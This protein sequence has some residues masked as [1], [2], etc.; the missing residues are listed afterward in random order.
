MSKRPAPW[1]VW[2]RATGAMAW[3]DWL[4][5]GRS[6]RAAHRGHQQGEHGLA[7][8]TVCSA[9]FGGAVRM[10]LEQRRTSRREWKR[11]DRE[12]AARRKVTS[13]SH[14]PS[15]PTGGLDPSRP[16]AVNLIVP[17]RVYIDT[18]EGTDDPASHTPPVPP[19]HSTPC[20]HG[21]GCRRRVGPAFEPA[22]GTTHAHGAR[23]G[24]ITR[25]SRT[26]IW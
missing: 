18:L 21:P 4:R 22:R 24:P 16:S 26:P 11:H 1:G 14:R 5:P 10:C 13:P 20:T 7:H 8:A 23:C 15:S 17:S 25:G 19:C 3:R 6:G 12:S 9:C 2:F